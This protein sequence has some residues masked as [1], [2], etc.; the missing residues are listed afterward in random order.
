MLNF[1]YSMNSN[2]YCFSFV[3]FLI[4]ACFGSCSADN[5]DV[6]AVQEVERVNIPANDPPVFSGDITVKTFEV[7]D[8]DSK[9]T[10]GW[11]YD[12]YIAPENDHPAIHQSNIPAIQGNKSFSTEEKARMT[13]EYAASKMKTTGSLPT[14]TIKELDSLGV[15]Q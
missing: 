7:K 15:T 1:N 2:S 9:K 8:K 3:F 6:A 12:L 5:K 13:G 4:S 10:I 14:I 11:G